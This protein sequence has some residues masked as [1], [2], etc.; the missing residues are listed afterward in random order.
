MRSVRGCPTAE[1]AAFV[2]RRIQ[3]E[4]HLRSPLPLHQVSTQRSA[5]ARGVDPSGQF[6]ATP[7]HSVRPGAAFQGWTIRFVPSLNQRVV[8]PVGWPASARIGCLAAFLRRCGGRTAAAINL[9]IEYRTG[10]AFPVA[11][12][13]HITRAF[14]NL[15]VSQVTVA[16]PRFARRWSLAPASIVDAYRLLRCRVR[17]MAVPLNC[18]PPSRRSPPGSALPASQPRRRQKMIAAADVNAW[19]VKRG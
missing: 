7:L 12:D 17:L 2:Q 4:C 16:P 11:P 15:A 14:C 8:P 6:R 13:V 9:N 3:T 10:G 18:P 19:R 5:A 1:L